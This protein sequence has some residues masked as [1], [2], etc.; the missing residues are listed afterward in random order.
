[1]KIK[2]EEKIDRQLNLLVTNFKHLTGE[3][4]KK[5]HLSYLGLVGLYCILNNKLQVH[6]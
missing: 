3:K 6:N 4:K 1:V 5:H 2:E